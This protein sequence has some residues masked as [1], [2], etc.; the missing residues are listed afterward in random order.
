MVESFSPYTKLSKWGLTSLPVRQAGR[1][2]LH[3]RLAGT[4]WLARTL[5]LPKGLPSEGRLPSRRGLLFLEGNLLVNRRLLPS[6][7]LV[8]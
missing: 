4:L 2:D 8:L 5:A 6:H 1:F 7:D 3:G